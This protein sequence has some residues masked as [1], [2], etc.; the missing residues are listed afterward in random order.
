MIVERCT[1]DRAGQLARTLDARSLDESG[2]ISGSETAWRPGRSRSLRGDSLGGRRKSPVVV[3]HH[4]DACCCRSRSCR[5][6]VM[7][8]S[9]WPSVLSYK[10]RNAGIHWICDPQE[11]AVELLRGAVP[12]RSPG[13]PGHRETGLP[14]RRLPELPPRRQRPPPPLDRTTSPGRCGRSDGGTTPS[15][16][17]HQPSGRFRSQVSFKVRSL[18][19]SQRLHSLGRT[20]Q[21]H[22]GSSVS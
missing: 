5:D 7:K 15:Q 2:R 22:Q 16:E 13:A 17:D 19:T 8:C 4:H 20:A 6:G 1:R 14:G 10:I 9:E 18:R 12:F 3:A 21:C 11:A